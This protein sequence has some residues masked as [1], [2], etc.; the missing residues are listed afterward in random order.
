MTEQNPTEPS[1]S[2]DRSRGESRD[3]EYETLGEGWS[4]FW[5]SNLGLGLAAAIVA[6]IG[7]AMLLGNLGTLGIWEPWE[8]KEILVAQ[9]YDDRSDPP[10]LE[11]RGLE[12]PSYNWA[13]PTRDGEPVARSLLKTWLISWSIVDGVG[14]QGDPKVGALEFSA[15]FPIALAMLLLTVA[16]FFWLRNVF[17]TWSALLGSAAFATT[18]AI[19][20]GVHT[21]SS[22]S[23]FVVTTSMALLAF[24]KLVYS[25]GAWR[26]LW[27]T[28]FGIGLALSFL[29]QRFFGLLVPVTTIVAFG[30]TQLPFRLAAAEQSP[31]KETILGWPEKL[32][33]PIALLAGGAF[34]AWGFWR[35]SQIRGE[36]W[37]LPHIEQLFAV[38]L[39]GFLLLAGLLFAWRTR[40]IRVLRRP[41]GLLGLVIATTTIVVVLEAYADANPTLLKHGR[42][43]GTIP[44]LE[45]VL[46]NELFGVTFPD[47]R[48]H[49]A[50]WVRHLGFSMVPWAAFVPLGLGYLARSARLTD[51]DGALRSSNLSE[52]ESLRRFLLVWSFVGVLVVGGASLY[53]HYYFP[54]YFPMLVAAGAM[55]GDADFWR[56]AR[57]DTVLGYFMGFAAIALLYMFAKDLERFPARLLESYMMFEEEVGLPDNFQYG[58]ILDQLKYLWLLTSA[59][60]FFGLLSRMLHEKYRDVFVPAAYFGVLA[61]LPYALGQWLGPVVRFA[62]LEAAQ[63]AGLGA[64]LAVWAGAVVALPVYRLFFTDE[65]TYLIRM[66]SIGGALGLTAG[67]ALLGTY[68]PGGAVFFVFSALFGLGTA[69]LLAFREREAAIEWGERRWSRLKELFSDEGSPMVERALE[70]EQF[71]RQS[72]WWSRIARFFETAPTFGAVLVVVLAGSAGVLLYDVAPRLGHHLSQ[73]GIFETYT[74]ISEEDEKLHRLRVST[75]ETSVYLRD[76]PRMQNTQK[77]LDQYDQKERFFAVIPRGQLSSL[78]KKVRES[79]EEN[80]P[81]LDA[82]SSRLLLVSNKLREGESDANFIADAIVEDRSEIQHEVTFESEGESRHPVFEDRLKLLGYTLDKPGEEPTYGWGETIK[83]STYFEVLK[84]VPTNQKIFLHVDYPGSR[85]HGDHKPVGGDFPTG[86]WLPGDVVKDVHELEVDAY[87]STGTYTMYFGFYRTGN[88]M[89]VQ[90]NSAHDGQN[91]VPMG[92]IRVTGF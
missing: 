92:K 62:H 51:D 73:R 11:E 46:Q 21:V 31:K 23:L 55:F 33:T 60:F 75:R 57:L 85:I 86:D 28:L 66:T 64:T 13:V 90:P 29:D 41:P 88:R 89:K 72:G 5:E 37:L 17:D 19:F 82:R 54:A 59:V 49:F 20:M 10:P 12:A 44:V 38:G 77:F 68:L 16:G 63:I 43:V 26:Y 58:A 4:Q 39:P 87:S 45:Y 36:I 56:R 25:E 78:N 32:L 7:G 65:P 69:Y 35:S 14:E 84:P 52:R 81:V 40:P 30:L 22:E 48:L 74:T 9:E 1:P 50:M 18:P 47:G 53:D 91:R 80:I 24:A 34:A 71:R 8:A 6:A 27:G 83:L 2:R 70:K 15:R 79:Y 3:K 76:V 67:T 42:V 61:G